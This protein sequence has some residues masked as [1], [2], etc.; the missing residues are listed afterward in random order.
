M[1]K[2]NRK[3]KEQVTREGMG[4]TRMGRSLK[5]VNDDESG[6]GCPEVVCRRA[7]A[8]HESWQPQT[9]RAAITEREKS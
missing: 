9:T 2:K 4:K 1:K 6:C 3:M 8:Q 7:R 5:G